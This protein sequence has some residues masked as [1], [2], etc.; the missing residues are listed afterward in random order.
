MSEAEL[1]AKT[2]RSLVGKLIHVKAL[3]P[4]GR[5]N[6]DKIMWMYKTAVRTEAA[7]EVSQRAGGSSD[8]G[9]FS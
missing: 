4:G 5:F 9:T 2:V 8:S 3:V 6:I 1:P 7:V